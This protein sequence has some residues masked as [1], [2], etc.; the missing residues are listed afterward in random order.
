MRKNLF[1]SEN[2]IYYM[3]FFN[4]FREIFYELV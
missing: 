1:S 2:V 4:F 3:D